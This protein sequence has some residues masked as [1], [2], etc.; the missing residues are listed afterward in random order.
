MSTIVKKLCSCPKSNNIRKAFVELNKIVHATYLLEYIDVLELR[1]NVYSALNRTE[2]YHK[3]KKAV[4][5][6]NGGKIIARTEHEQL[7]YQEC[8]RLV[9]NAIVYY[10]SDILSRF[11]IKKEKLGQI[12]QIQA[13]KHISPL[14]WIHI[15]LYGKYIFKDNPDG[16]SSYQLDNFLKGVSLVD[17]LL[18]AKVA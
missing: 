16:M 18:E 1:Q 14:A 6:A 4:K 9:C 3:L 10:N 17:E 15:N 5:F 12:K 13:L 2:N 11:L 7:I 8:C